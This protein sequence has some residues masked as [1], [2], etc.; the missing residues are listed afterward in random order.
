MIRQFNFGQYKNRNSIIHLLDPRL[1]IILVVLL[2]LLI[3]TLNS[4]KILIFTVFIVILLIL[5]KIDFVY[6]IVNLRAFYS[7]MIFIL[8]MYLLFAR[9]QIYEG[10]IVIWRFL[11]LVL[12]SFVLTYTTTI[13]ML[14]AGI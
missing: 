2:S 7:F 12:L 8:V 4:Y 1:K 6:L 13:S 14:I 10:F 9:N 3:F 5:S 11:I